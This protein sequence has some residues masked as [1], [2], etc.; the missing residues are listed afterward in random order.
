ML[1]YCTH[2]LAAHNEERD[3]SM[4]YAINAAK[5]STNVFAVELQII[6]MVLKE[7]LKQY[8]GVYASPKLGTTEKRSSIY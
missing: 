7:E 3:I 6:S 1:T 2:A 8:T 5:K 4:T